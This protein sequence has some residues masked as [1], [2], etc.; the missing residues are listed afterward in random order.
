MKVQSILCYGDS[1]TWGRD[2]DTRGRFD[3]GIRWTCLVQKALGE[4]FLVIEEGL[5]G[6][7]TVR[8]DPEWDNRNG[9]TFLPIVLETHSPL[10]IAIFAL[11]ANDLK[12]RFNLSPREIAEGVRELLDCAMKGSHAPASAVIVCP[13][14][15]THFI[16][17]FYKEFDG[18]VEKSQELAR[19]YSA[20]AKEFK[21]GFVDAGKFLKPSSLDGL[22]FDAAGHKVFAEK[23]VDYIT[24]ITDS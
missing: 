22:H 6:R 3:T 13:P 23:M 11:G 8:D 14:P 4:K 15:C 19:Y 7:T 10:D 17:E 18:A 12:S 2:P 9:K 21:C 1:N 20:V 5:V 16:Y 24:N